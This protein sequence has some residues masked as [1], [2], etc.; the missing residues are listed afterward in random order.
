[1]G[2]DNSIEDRLPDKH[3]IEL[4]G[5]YADKQ[6]IRSFDRVAVLVGRTQTDGP[7]AERN[8]IAVDYVVVD[9]PHTPND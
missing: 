2:V 6:D 8:G 5:Y 9:G 7:F 3:V 4:M 1:M